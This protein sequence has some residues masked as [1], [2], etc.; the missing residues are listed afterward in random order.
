MPAI[1]L[2]GW[3][4]LVA[5]IVLGAGSQGVVLSLPGFVAALVT[6]LALTDQGAGWVVVCLGVGGLVGALAAM[7]MVTRSDV[8]R[9]VLWQLVALAALEAGCVF[10]PSVAGVCLLQFVAGIGIGC[11]GT[12]AFGIIARGDK[13]EATIGIV[14][15]MQLLVGGLLIVALPTVLRLLPMRGGFFLFLA[16][17][18]IALGL[19]SFIFVPHLPRPT[20]REKIE[21]STFSW[22]VP[23]FVGLAAVLLANA[24]FSAE[25]TYVAR[26]GTQAVHMGDQAAATAV[27][28]STAAGIMGG[29]LAGAVGTRIGRIAPV[30][31]SMAVMV[32]TAALLMSEPSAASFWVSC[33]LGNF[34][35][36]YCAVPLTGY[37]AHLDVFGRG[38]TAASF[39]LSMGLAVG[40]LFAAGLVGR[41]YALV[42]ETSI[43]G[44]V[45]AAV[46]FAQAVA[47]QRRVSSDSGC[48]RGD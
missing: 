30:V 7:G 4:F 3:R 39:T 11:I 37:F 5:V 27:S 35:F 10:V 20:R 38:S 33:C 44:F 43:V 16:A 32:L 34:A 29:F 18:F 15:A 2:S 12:L 23:L 21:R 25:W 24:A 45:A 17:W 1:R 36:T 42:L 26:I 31:C 9:T 28:V 48:C 14:C 13:P 22:G 40:P 8:R 41:G 19:L 47:L 46:V 6:D